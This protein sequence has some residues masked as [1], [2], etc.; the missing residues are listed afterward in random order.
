MNIKRSD[1]NKQ[2]ILNFAVLLFAIFPVLPNKIKGLPVVFLVLVSLIY[3]KR[4]K[5]NFRFFLLNTSLYI[6]YLL[7][8]FSNHKGAIG[9]LLETSSSML[10]LP[11]VFNVLISHVRFDQRV[12]LKFYNL[13]ITSTFLFA[14]LILSNVLLDDAT[15]YYSNWYTNKARTIIENS[16]FIGQH[17]IYASVFFG[18]S[19]LFAV[20]IL[21]NTENKISN[22][23]FYY[24]AVFFNLF[25]LLFFLSKG[26]VLA[27]LITLFA[28]FFTNAK[29]TKKRIAFLLI[30][31]F[32]ISCLFTFN[33]RMNEL[34]NIDTYKTVNTNYS[35]GLR[36]GIYK[37]VYGLAK[38]NWILGY[39]PGN[40][41][42]VLNDC[43]ALDSPVLLKKIYNSHNQYLDVLL[44]TGIFGLLVFLS[45]LIIN[46]VKAK[47]N[48]N[49]IVTYILIFYCIIFLI[50]NILLR[51]SGVI[52]FYFFL[53]F[54]NKVDSLKHNENATIKQL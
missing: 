45:F 34:I 17:P 8:F 54:F 25:L 21:K 18:M 3:F 49:F 46:Y 2:K 44:K 26:V 12:R 20:D 5:I 48:K 41:Q 35:T 23:L 19:I 30:S 9:S 31:V 22:K 36:V 15:I 1:F 24:G 33:R 10:F 40:T 13:F 11:L 32:L 42:E 52:L 47:E 16:I 39:G 29:W 43:Y 50:E 51:Q 53:T 27:L 4:I 37:C 7:A 38:D 14:I 6:I 28:V